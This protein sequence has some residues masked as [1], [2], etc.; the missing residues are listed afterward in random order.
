[1]NNKGKFVLYILFESPFLQSTHL[2]LTVGG[3]PV[4]IT[5]VDPLALWLLL[6]FSQ[7]RTLAEN[8]K[9]K[10][11][12]ELLISLLPSFLHIGL[13]NVVYRLYQKTHILEVSLYIY[14]FCFVLFCFINVLFILMCNNHSHFCFPKL[15]PYFLN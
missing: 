5:L 13:E 6:G 3:W 14:I 7:W 15:C 9:L 10:N 8:W 1:M 4:C 12:D 11:E 2:Y